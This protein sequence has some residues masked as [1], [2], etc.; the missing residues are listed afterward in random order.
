MQ[1]DEQK[2][3]EQ[4]IQREIRSGREVTLADLISQEGGDFLK[5]ESPVPKLVQVTTEIKLF[6]SNNLKDTEGALQSVLQTLVETEQT[7]VSHH[8]DT[9]L[10]ALKVILNQLLT[11][12][13][14][15]FE[16]VR[17]VDSKWGQM[18]GERPYFQQPGQDAHPNDEYTH[19]SVKKQL[20]NLLNQIE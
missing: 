8:L 17:R 19:E 7:T 1:S 13:S 2:K 9:P 6:I 11:N 4:E 10:D 15:L 5:G 12:N 3:R 14:L 16:L 20:E 18:Y